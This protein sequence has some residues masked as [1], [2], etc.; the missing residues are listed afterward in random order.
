MKDK[1][2]KNKFGRLDIPCQAPMENLPI[3]KRV[4]Q[5]NKGPTSP[6][7]GPAKKFNCCD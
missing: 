4:N 3:T 1:K 6:R 7:S 2:G 5:A